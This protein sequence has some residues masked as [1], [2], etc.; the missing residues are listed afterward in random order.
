[1]KIIVLSRKEELYS[2]R[3]LVESIR[4]LGHEAEV[5]NYLHCFITIERDAPQLLYKEDLL[6]DDMDAVIPRIGAT[7][8]SFGL[9]RRFLT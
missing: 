1:M 4:S 7:Y 3:R 9:L 6:L 2:T 5:L 8:T